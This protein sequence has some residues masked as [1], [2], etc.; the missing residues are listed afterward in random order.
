MGS[1]EFESALGVGSDSDTGAYLSKG[2]CS[3]VDLDIDVVVFEETECQR[4]ASDASAD[5][6]DAKALW[7]GRISHGDVGGRN[8]RE[9]CFCRTWKSRLLRC[10]S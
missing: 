2:V 1:Y 3:F 7:L 10:L 8:C 4:Q 9:I 5:N 6:G